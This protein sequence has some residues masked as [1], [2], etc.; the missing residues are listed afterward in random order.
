MYSFGNLLWFFV[1]ATGVHAAIFNHP[2]PEG[3]TEA[4]L[5]G[6][7]HST[8]VQTLGVF[9]SPP[10]VS[11]G[12]LSQPEIAK[13]SL[14]GTRKVSAL[15][16]EDQRF[17]VH[18]RLSLPAHRDEVEVKGDPWTMH[19]FM[20]FSVFL[21]FGG[22]LLSVIP[23]LHY[24][25]HFFHENIGSDEDTFK[26][27][28]YYRFTD[29]FTMK[30]Y[31]PSLVLLL[32]TMGLIVVGSLCYNLLV[33]ESP[34][35]AL[36]RIFVW[37][38]GSPAES[39]KTPGG[40]FLGVLVTVCGLIILSLLLG[41]VTEVFTSKMSEIKQ[42]LS[43]VVEGGHV[44]MI[45]YTECTRC[46]IEELVNARESEGGGMFIILT[47]S[48]KDQV[49]NEL[50]NNSLKLHSSRLVVRSGSPCCIRDLHKA[51]VNSAS[52]VVILSSTDGESQEEADAKS[53]RVL[54]ALKSKGWPV[55]GRIIVQVACPANKELFSSLNPDKV[56]VVV[57]GNIM[58]K[59]M[60]RSS[61][62]FGMA[63]VFGM[64]LGFDGDEFYSQEWPE[65]V[66][67]T[68]H[69]IVFRMPQAAV[70]GIFTVSGTCILNP[71]WGRKLRKGE[72]LI[73][74]AE[75]NDSYYP[76]DDLYFQITAPMGSPTSPWKRVS[77]RSFIHQQTERENTASSVLVIGWNGNVEP[78][79]TS[80]DGM[81]GIGSTIDV[82]STVP[83]VDREAEIRKIEQQH[84]MGEGFEAITI[85]H[86]EVDRA[87]ATSR[88]EL[89]RLRHYEKDKVFILA[90]GETNTHRDERTLAVL[91]QLQMIMRDADTKRVKPFN[92][93]VEMCEDSTKEHLQICGF[94]NFVHSSSLIS[95]ALAAVTE[96]P[97]VNA[98]YA[99]LMSGIENE[100]DIRS[101]T[102][103]LPDGILEPDELAFGE[104]AWNL[105][106]LGEMALLGW[107]YTSEDGTRT[108][109]LN[110]KDK[111]TSRPWS[112]EERVVLIRRFAN[113]PIETPLNSGRFGDMC[114]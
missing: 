90:E 72:H 55:K 101:Y 41:I 37:A 16:S 104:A 12:T 91:A 9:H 8:I 107:S 49:E 4:R 77:D 93:V 24:H 58:A 51:A 108:W 44:V 100:F 10:E 29:W 82:Y 30:Q 64:M 68:F 95:Q 97:K 94:N 3:A 11:R 69:E 45:G 56:E 86:H 39:E 103:F 15:I 87:V 99:E 67:K 114:A 113:L 34:S 96:E 70:M 81:V 32:L 66:G 78:L 47:Q 52:K 48:N 106:C 110:P 73:V 111:I 61:Q 36:F 63:T 83:T 102:D 54:L 74:L 21:A 43:K 109:E 20:G 35:H 18:D 80:L 2:V 6:F 17:L 50:L 14:N 65:L 1:C 27:Y 26:D 40:R 33:G 92:P 13:P 28:L 31:A 46:L 59:L 53:I 5:R 98:I 19:H 75:D 71:G 60:S 84:R 89:Q 105:A 42:G 112:S 79:F 88:L 62:Q 38:S 23:L 22:F 7:G 57:V 25:W 76:E 85:V